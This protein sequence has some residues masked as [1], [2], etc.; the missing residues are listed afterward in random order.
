MFTQPRLQIARSILKLSAI[1]THNQHK[2]VLR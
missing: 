1:N 2:F